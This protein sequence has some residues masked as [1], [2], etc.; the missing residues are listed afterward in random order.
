MPHVA[1]SFICQDGEPFSEF[2][3]LIRARGRHGPTAQSLVHVVNPFRSDNDGVQHSTLDSLERARR[4][5]SACGR[6]ALLRQVGVVA[7][8]E[9]P[10][11]LDGLDAV[12]SLDGNDERPRV[13]DV[14][15]CVRD[16]RGDFVVFTNMDICV[17]VAFYE[18]VRAL[19]ALGCDA[20]IINRRTV[21]APVGDALASF[22]LGEPH[23]GMDCF[24]F[25]RAW[26][27]GFVRSEAVIGYGAVMR[28]LLYNLVARAELFAF[29]RDAHF[30]HH[31]GDD[32]VWL[33]R[34]DMQT[35]NRSEAGRVFERLCESETARQRLGQFVER[36]PQYRAE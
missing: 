25:P 1:E 8:G 22:D 6:G 26:I 9:Q 20:L 30:T 3:A 34:E 14:L 5:E 27:D 35:F 29:V 7:P 32:R 17:S 12:L 31:F 33:E 24:V 16:E 11:G 28:G 19:L 23:P 18:G 21:H 15:D 13:F 4:W 2:V 36:M 10:S